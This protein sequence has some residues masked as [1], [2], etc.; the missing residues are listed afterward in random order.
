MIKDCW[1]VY[2]SEP[3]NVLGY[4]Q[5]RSDASLALA[6]FQKY[7]PRVCIVHAEMLCRLFNESEFTVHYER[8]F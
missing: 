2:N 8:L 7:E 3:F 5:S 1:I 4:F 6:V